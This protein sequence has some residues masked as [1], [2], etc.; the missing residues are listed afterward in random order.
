MIGTFAF[1][2]IATMIK[3]LIED[4]NRYKQDKVSNARMVMRLNCEGWTYVKCSTPR[5]GEIVKILKEEEFSSDCLIIS[6]SNTNGYCY[7]DTKNLDSETNLKEKL[8]IEEYS[9]ISEFRFFNGSVK[10]DKPNE[11]LHMFKG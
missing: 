8:S 11:N 3:E 4:Y 9:E 1:V 7:I 6:L 5:P 2:L 10:C